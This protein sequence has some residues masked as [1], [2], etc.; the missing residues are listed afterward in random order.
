MFK[1]SSFERLWPL[2]RSTEPLRNATDPSPP[3]VLNKPEHLLWSRVLSKYT[4]RAGVCDAGELT[5]PLRVY[6]LGARMNDS[7]TQR[8][9]T[10]KIKGKLK[11]T[12]RPAQTPFG[13]TKSV[14]FAPTLNALHKI[15]GRQSTTVTQRDEKPG[16]IRE[17]FFK[18]NERGRLE[19]SVQR[20]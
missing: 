4:H 11:E 1:L 2:N 19:Q 17:R 12:V 7:C 14:I 8:A 6:Q 20:G 15:F 10:K 3:L 5:E 9:V 18:P 16:L 13:I